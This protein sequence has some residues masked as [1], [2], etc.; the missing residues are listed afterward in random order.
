MH[1]PRNSVAVTPEGSLL[2]RKFQLF[3]SKDSTSSERHNRTFVALLAC[4]EATT[5][6][7]VL[8]VNY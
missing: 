4:V 5:A 2:L 8:A 3:T 7:M 6:I 1:G